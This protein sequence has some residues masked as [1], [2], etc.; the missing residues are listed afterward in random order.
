MPLTCK[1]IEV[2]R[3]S[4][5]AAP[6]LPIFGTA[7]AILSWTSSKSSKKVNV[8]LVESLMAGTKSA[9]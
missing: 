9:G 5:T 6:S 3:L 2:F 4:I 1:S 8:S 7:P